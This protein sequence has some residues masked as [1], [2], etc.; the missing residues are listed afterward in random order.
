LLK[1]NLHSSIN[2]F[3][4]PEC[5]VPSKYVWKSVVKR[6]IISRETQLWDYRTSVD[7]DIVFFQIIYPCIRTC[8]IYK[9]CNRTS[10]RNTM[11]VISRLWS[12]P[13]TVENRTCINCCEIYQEE[14]VHVIYECLTTSELRSQFLDTISDI[15]L[16]EQKQS[17]LLQDSVSQ[18]LKLLG[19]PIE[20][21]LD[22]VT[23]VTFLRRYIV[24]IISY[25]IVTLI[26]YIIT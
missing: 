18:T 1:Y 10:L 14:L 13:V 11:F 4:A 16:P 22:C 9:V 17:L 23:E 21:I 7:T 15:L 20:P 25:Y 19:A 2:N 26:C 24:M 5:Y 6:S 8:I 12:R 3:L